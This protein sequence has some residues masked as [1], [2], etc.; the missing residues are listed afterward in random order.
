MEAFFII[1]VMPDLKIKYYFHH[2][3]IQKWLK[4]LH[5]IWR[6]CINQL[7]S[8]SSS[9]FKKKRKWKNNIFSEAAPNCLA[10]CFG[11]PQPDALV[12]IKI[13]PRSTINVARPLRRTCVCERGVELYFFYNLGVLSGCLP[14]LEYVL[15][16]CARS[17][18][19]VTG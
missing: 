12:K 2:F 18:L 11:Q 6:I 4:Y 7:K 9:E 19:H 1:E 8:F 14:F 17:P 13:T 15:L 10:K 16:C 5:Y 3:S